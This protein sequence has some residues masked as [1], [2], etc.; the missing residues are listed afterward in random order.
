MPLKK[1]TVIYVTNEA[2]QRVK[3]LDD[4]VKIQFEYI[5][6]LHEYQEKLNGMSKMRLGAKDNE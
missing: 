5:R 6:L 4:I 3:D 2:N 1:N